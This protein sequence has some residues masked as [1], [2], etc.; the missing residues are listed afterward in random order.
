MGVADRKKIPD[1]RMTASSLH[2]DV[3]FRSY[4]GRL[5]DMGSSGYRAWCPSSVSDRSDFLQIDMGEEYTV[6]AV[7]TQGDSGGDYTKS[8]KLKFSTD[9]STWL[10]YRE[11]NVEKV[12]RAIP[13]KA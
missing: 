4:F 5:N 9:G 1:A 10:T 2:S 7:A 8:Y 6:C 3:T 12:R 11:E 13:F